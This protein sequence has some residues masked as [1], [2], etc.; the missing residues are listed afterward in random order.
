MDRVMDRVV[1]RVMDRV[2][3]PGRGLGALRRWKRCQLR[4]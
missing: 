4:D 2:P 3:V 1:G